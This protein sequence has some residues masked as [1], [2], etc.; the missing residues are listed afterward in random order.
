VVASVGSDESGTNTQQQQI[1]TAIVGGILALISTLILLR[2]IRSRHSNPKYIPT[3][4]LKRLWKSWNVP[5]HIPSHAYS[6]TGNIDDAGPNSRQLNPT[7]ELQGNHT[8]GGGATSLSRTPSAAPSRADDGVDRTQSVR[9]VMTL[10]VYRQKPGEHEQVL[11]REGERDGIDVVVEMPTAE[12]EEELRDEEMEALYQIRV[13]RRRQLA[14]REERRRLRRE[15]RE[16][17]NLVALQEL[18]ER[19]QIEAERNQQEIAELRQEHERLRESRNRVVGSV[20]YAAVGIAR[21]DG[22]RIRANSTESER[23]GLLDDAASMGDAGA[24]PSPLLHR[25]DRS[26]SS[27]LSIDTLRSSNELTP[28]SPALT[29]GGGSTFSLV[30][31]A[32]RTRS[33][34]RGNSAA[35]TTRT[36]RAGSSPEIIDSDDADLGD[37]SMPPP[38]YDDV[39]LDDIT[40]VRSEAPSVLSG[41]NSP[42]NEPP[43]DY[44]GPARTR[45]N[46]LSAQM[47]NLAAGQTSGENTGHQRQ[48]SRGE[49]GLAHLPSLRLGQLPQIVIEPS[50]E[51]TTDQTKDKTTASR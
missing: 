15:A 9:S 19:A 44:P 8:D 4:F 46:R 1:I 14:E 33:R 29:T 16:Q 17:R 6:R 20:S 24:R 41:R 25:R 12:V 2:L 18:R 31:D 26:A 43:P 40:P 45:S 28:E 38:G 21:A 11:G 13:A 35:T 39:N 22:T 32:A 51:Q 23:V 50:T 47:E 48:S 30:G 36:T 7:T 3:P 37:H 42:Y 34:S 5:E 10:P 49:G 27:V